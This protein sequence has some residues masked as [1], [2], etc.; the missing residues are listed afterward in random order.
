MQY[1][2][3]TLICS[4]IHLDAYI[5]MRLNQSINIHRSLLRVKQDFEFVFSSVKMFAFTDHMVQR[6]IPLA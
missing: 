6:S 4:N 2:K 1:F 3:K 5:H